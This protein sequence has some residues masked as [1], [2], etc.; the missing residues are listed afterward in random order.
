MNL[1]QISVALGIASTLFGGIKWLISKLGN[2][3]KSFISVENAELAMRITNT[4]R[5]ILE[6]KG[7][8]DALR[9]QVEELRTHAAASRIAFGEI[10]NEVRTTAQEQ[11][12]SL[13]RFEK[14]SVEWLNSEYVRVTGK[15]E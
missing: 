1:E 9:K 15:R 3:L 8:N 5:Q 14:S 13:K 7:Q 10:A 12:E 4:Q 2:A 11:R 6:I